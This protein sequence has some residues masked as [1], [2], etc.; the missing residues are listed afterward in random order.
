MAICTFQP[1]QEVWSLLL[2]HVAMGTH[3]HLSLLSF[4]WNHCKSAE[5]GTPL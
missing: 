1:S 2:V 5:Q 4:H 3:F